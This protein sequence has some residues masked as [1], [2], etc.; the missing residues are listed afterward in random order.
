MGW[1]FL[2]FIPLAPEVHFQSFSRSKVE[3][4]YYRFVILKDGVISI[5]KTNQWLIINRIA[6][7]SLKTVIGAAG[8]VFLYCLLKEPGRV[9]LELL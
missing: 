8:D 4:P 2:I 5:G 3:I 7:E 6:I 9:L 1:L